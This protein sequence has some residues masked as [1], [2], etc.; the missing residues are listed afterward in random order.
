MIPSVRLDPASRWTP[1]NGRLPHLTGSD[2]QYA[3]AVD[4]HVG[5]LTVITEGRFCRRIVIGCGESDL[6]PSAFTDWTYPRRIHVT[7]TQLTRPWP[8][9]LHTKIQSPLSVTA[10]D[11]MVQPGIGPDIATDLLAATPGRCTPR[12]PGPISA[13]SSRSRPNRGGTPAACAART[14]VSPGHRRAPAHRPGAHCGRSWDHPR[15]RV[16]K[17][18]DV[19]SAC[20][21][22]TGGS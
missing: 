5:T 10:P 17:T 18:R 12:P 1:P 9:H 21:H 11:L 19:M 13:V 15:L 16:T 8:H 6:Q 2:R 14:A 3:R 7:F 4:S 22:R 20:P